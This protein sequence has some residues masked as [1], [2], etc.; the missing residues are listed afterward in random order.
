MTNLI[1]M[2]P[3]F[4]NSANNSVT[5]EVAD[6]KEPEE[7]AET[8][9]DSVVTDKETQKMS[10]KVAKMA[11]IMSGKKPVKGQTVKKVVVRKK[12]DPPKENILLK[13]NE[14]T[15]NARAQYL[16]EQ[17]EKKKAEEEKRKKLL[18]QIKNDNLIPVETDLEIEKNLDPEEKALYDIIHVKSADVDF[19]WGTDMLMSRILKWSEESEDI[20][21]LKMS[22]KAYHNCDVL[23]EKCEPYLQKIFD[24][25]HKEKA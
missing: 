23:Y 2:M 9:N 5:A 20:D 13:H 21:D 14:K 22:L 11:A 12:S 8:D 1:L 24:L 10:E 4:P 16:K 19:S 3:T 25:T 18:Q 17:E 6:E 15:R 7:T